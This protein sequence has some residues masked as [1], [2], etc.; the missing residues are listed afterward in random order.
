MSNKPNAASRVPDLFILCHNVPEVYVKYQGYRIVELHYNYPKPYI[1]LAV[2]VTEKEA[3]QWLE[4]E[5]GGRSV[6]R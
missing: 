3:Q 2:E 6:K 5:S 1:M 4:K